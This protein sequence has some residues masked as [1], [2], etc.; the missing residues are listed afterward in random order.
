V[1]ESGADSSAAPADHKVGSSDAAE[2][3]D[4]VPQSLAAQG[5]L[6]LGHHQYLQAIK[7]F[8]KELSRSPIN[9]TALFGLAE[10]YRSSGRRQHALDA[11]R[12][13]VAILP[14]GPNVGSARFHIRNLE[15]KM[16]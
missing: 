14:H 13:Y 11:Y 9:G 7:L 1:P 4:K 2:A 16:R 8:H 15:A 5:Y 3:D 10:A 12:R 6:A